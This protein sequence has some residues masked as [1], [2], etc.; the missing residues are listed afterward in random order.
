MEKEE[1]VR[2]SDFKGI[3]K[4]K[5]KKGKSQNDKTLEQQNNRYIYTEVNV[6]I[7]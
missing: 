6:W 5:E 7:W 3:G 1:Q 2:Q 4:V